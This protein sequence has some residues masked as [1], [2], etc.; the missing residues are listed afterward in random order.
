MGLL[1]NLLADSRAASTVELGLIFAFIVIAVFGAI[2]SLGNETTNSFNSTANK[3]VEA[4][5]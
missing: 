3:V 2:G 4:T 5:K 1:E